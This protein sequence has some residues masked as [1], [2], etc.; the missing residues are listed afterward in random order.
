MEKKKF[1][2]LDIIKFIVVVALCAIF[3]K[4]AYMTT[5]KHEH[6]N[7]LA[8]NKTY[9]E[10]PVKA[11]RGEIKDR[12]GRTIA[13]NRNS[14]TVHISK[15]GIEKKDKS[16]K[17]RANEISLELI[18]LLKKNKEEY[19]DEFPIYVE[20]GKYFYIFDKKIR[21]F[22][23]ENKIPLDYNAKQSFYYMVDKAIEEHKIDA[24]VRDLK[25]EEIQKKLNSAGIY[26]PILV[27]DWKFTEQRNK[28]DWL[29]SYKIDNINT[30]AKDAFKDVRKYYKIPS[31]LSNDDA[32][33]I[34]IVRDLLKSQG[35]VQYKPVTIAKDIT[36]DTISQIEERAM[37]LPGVSIAVEPV[38]DYPDKNLASHVLGTMGRISEQELAQKQ[39]NGESGYTK[40]DVV[41]KTGIEKFYED[42]L[43][44]KDGYKKVE[45]DSVG[46]VSKELAS[47]APVSG[48]TVYLSLDKDLQKVSDDS[49]ARVV[50]AGRSG[51]TFKSKFGD[52]SAS[53]KAA[54]NLESGATVVIDV[55]TGDILAMSSY[56][57]Y[58]PNLF[59][60][61]ISSEDYEK[62]KPKNP[63]DVLKSMLKTFDNETENGK[64]YISYPMVEAIKD[65]SID[66]ICHE[67]N[68][69]FSNISI[70]RNYK[71]QVSDYALIND[72]KRLDII[73]WKFIIQKYINSCYCLLDIEH[74]LT[75]KES[76]NRV[77]PTL[78]FDK[79][80][81]KYINR[82]G[83]IM[84]LSAFPEFLIDYFKEEVLE[85]Y[86]NSTKLFNRKLIIE[87]KQLSKTI[88]DFSFEKNINY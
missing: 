7:E 49:L 51:G 81:H 40:N 66:T 19:L 85:R 56:P 23:L 12:Y 43:K 82:Y 55:K 42:K 4:I 13:T 9:K 60:T 11:P 36:Q 15:D 58:D 67:Q 88:D 77:T 20:N 68:N 29:K 69:C 84:V 6:Y 86:L 62:L 33:S 45:V 64:M 57:D 8:K 18:N 73:G 10:I 22:K 52:Y 75:K 16:G 30:N 37:Q 2:R 83:Y 26:P 79:Q 70:G 14:F 1:D 78:I 31:N 25:P 80:R 72:F 21:E 71:K 87:C 50:K 32:R 61:G 46:R 27:K 5:F 76:V 39:E 35:F 74:S 34:M 53:G 17:S 3:L 63:N 28:E 65:Y 41:G 48:D 54:P 47:S 44:G 24:S 38:R 59:A